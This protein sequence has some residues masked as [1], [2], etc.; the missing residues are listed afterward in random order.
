MP[1]INIAGTVVEF[2][3]SWDG[4]LTVTLAE[5]P[6]REFATRNKVLARR[7][8]DWYRADKDK[9]MIGRQVQLIIELNTDTINGFR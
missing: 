9:D 7:I 1:D 4:Q 6:H 3:V 8:K 5:Y 2:R